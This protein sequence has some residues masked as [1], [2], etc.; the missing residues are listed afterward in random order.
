MQ[1]LRRHSSLELTGPYTRP[2]AVDIEAA[3]SMLPSLKPTG[4]RHS[5][6]V[7]TG[8][9]GPVGHR[10]LSDPTGPDRPD[11]ENSGPEGASISEDFGHH[12]ATGPAGNGRILA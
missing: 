11:P 5:R 4:D 12:L 9:D 6:W 10:Q 2:Q 7:M 3:A 1:R 8:T